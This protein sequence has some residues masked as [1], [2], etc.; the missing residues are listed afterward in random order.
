MTRR[1]IVK[2]FGVIALF[3]LTGCQSAQTKAAHE[4]ADALPRALGPARHYD[5]RVEGSA[6][7][8]ARGHAR[9]I[10]V[11]GQGVRV[12][13]DATLDTLDLDARGVSFDPRAR[14]ITSVDRAS[15]T[16]AVG[17]DNLTRYV[18]AY[19]VGLP[20]LLVRLRAS[21]V[22]VELPVRVGGLHTTASLGGTLAPDARSAGRLDFVA[23]AADVGAVPLPVG[24]VNAALRLVNPVFDLSHIRVPITV[25]QAGV[26]NGR[27][28]LQGTADLNGFQPS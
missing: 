10:R 4:I 5:V 11:M 15:F 27:M 12:A 8:L 6:F 25:T 13:P 9:R 28:V 2:G 19:H 18:R 21:D 23:D 20:G 3:A 7:D 16:G 17:Q 22:L 1:H 26:V 24:L 14:R